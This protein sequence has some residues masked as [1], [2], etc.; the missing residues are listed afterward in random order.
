MGDYDLQVHEVRRLLA[1]RLA[2]IVKLLGDLV[3]GRHE[4]D[5]FE[6]GKAH[7]GEEPLAPFGMWNSGS[8]ASPI[9]S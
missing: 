5:G 4:R 2:R 9:S 8:S 7:R 6:T 1:T 3:M